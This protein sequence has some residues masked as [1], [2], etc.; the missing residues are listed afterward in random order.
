MVAGH[1]DL[2]VSVCVLC[3]SIHIRREK[4]KKERE[5]RE[6]HHQQIRSITK[7]RGGISVQENSFTVL[8]VCIHLQV[9]FLMMEIPTLYIFVFLLFF[10]DHWKK[11]IV[12]LF[13]SNTTKTAKGFGDEFYVCFLFLLTS[14]D[15]RDDSFISIKRLWEYI[16]ICIYINYY[17]CTIHT[18]RENARESFPMI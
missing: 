12:S 18:F 2:C 14:G 10:V 4:E 13:W 15:N 1:G 3:D 11:Q 16:Y 5:I 6:E 7:R 9:D 8:Q 17:V